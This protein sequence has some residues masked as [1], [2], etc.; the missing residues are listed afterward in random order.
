ML[1][2]G[3]FVFSCCVMNYK[4][5]CLKEHTV[6][7]VERAHSCV[8]GEAECTSFFQALGPGLARSHTTEAYMSSGCTEAPSACWQNSSPGCRTE[9]PVY[10]LAVAV[11]ISFDSFS[12]FQYFLPPVCLQHSSFLIACSKIFYSFY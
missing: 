9:V 7:W 4:C 12:G 8:G 6:V 3:L 1:R 5:G 11:G 10:L 2:G